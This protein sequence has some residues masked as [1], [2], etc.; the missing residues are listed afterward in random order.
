MIISFTK[1]EEHLQHNISATSS[2]CGSA[3]CPVKLTSSFSYETS[4]NSIPTLIIIPSAA[5]KHPFFSS[6]NSFI[7]SFTINSTLFPSLLLL[8]IFT[9]DWVSNARRTSHTLCVHLSLVFLPV[10][11]P[12]RASVFLC[13]SLCW[14]VSFCSTFISLINETEYSMELRSQSKTHV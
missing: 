2:L 6:V 5:N 1:K 13:L 4:A 14:L 7:L 8:L 10:R 12:L 11:A 3:I 9:L